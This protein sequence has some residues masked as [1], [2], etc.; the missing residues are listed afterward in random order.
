[1]SGIDNLR[2]G[3]NN[4][5]PNEWESISIQKLF[6]CLISEWLSKKDIIELL[7]SEETISKWWEF[8]Y[9]WWAIKLVDK[10]WSN[11]CKAFCQWGSIITCNK[12]TSCR[13]FQKA[14]S[15]FDNY[16]SSLN[17]ETISNLINKLDWEISDRIER[18]LVQENIKSNFVFDLESA[19]W[20]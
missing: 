3:E 19:S 14:N 16:I 6:D 12:W 18:I 1:M 9:I 4:W 2:G 20:M 13:N 5:F 15:R 7:N 17:R 11:T 10:N 8:I